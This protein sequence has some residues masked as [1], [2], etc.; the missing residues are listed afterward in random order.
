M[1]CQSRQSNNACPPQACPSC[2]HGAQGHVYDTYT[3]DTYTFSHAHTR[4]L[5]INT[6][7]HTYI[8]TY[9]Y[10]ATCHRAYTYTH[11]HIH[12]YT[13]TTRT[14]K[15]TKQKHTRTPP[16][17]PPRA[18]THTHTHTHTRT[19]TQS[20]ARLCRE[21]CTQGKLFSDVLQCCAPCTRVS[22]SLMYICVHTPE[23]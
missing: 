6:Y 1:P 18:H 19:H 5:N 8:H 15:H 7:I 11:T 21:A 17:P 14:H 23:I 9:S 16:S 20:Y 22:L 13:N 10:L 12:T 2:V 4:A 3:S